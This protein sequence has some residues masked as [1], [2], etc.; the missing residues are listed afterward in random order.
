MKHKKQDKEERTRRGG[1]ESVGNKNNNDNCDLDVGIRS[2]TDY[3]KNRTRQ[4][5]LSCVGSVHRTNVH[6]CHNCH[7]LLRALIFLIL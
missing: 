1:E 3:E 7:N 4:Q 5:D 6:N 2:C